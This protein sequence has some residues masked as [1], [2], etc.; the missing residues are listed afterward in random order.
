[1]I[2]LTVLAI[3]QLMTLLYD[4]S[5]MQLFAIASVLVS[6]AAIPIA[7]STSPMPDTP[8]A[9]S[10]DIPAVFSV[11]PIGALGC[12]ATGL[13]NGAF[14]A[15]APVFTWGI[16][17]ET[18]H[19]AWFMTAAV[20]GGAV[21]QWP[22]G[23]VSDRIGRRP[24]LIALPVTGAVFGIGLMLFSDTGS[25]QLI[26]LLGAAWGMFAFPLYAISVAYTNDYAGPHD[27]V[28]VSGSLLLLY[29]LGATI[30]PIAASAVLSVV[31]YRGLF[32][33]GAAIHM[34]LAAY[35][36]LRMTRVSL[37][38]PEEAVPFSDALTA[39][40]T[41][42]QVYEETIQEDIA[43]LSEQL[44]LDQPDAEQHGRK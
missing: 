34:L 22:L 43:G 23:T 42:S 1:M 30:G 33:F 2:T 29:G 37:T 41:A 32:A 24:L 44:C 4:P 21:A 18:S 31:G 40:Q 27:Y 19:A 25:F 8:H 13:T 36:I 7:L 16:S 28:T 10:I 39:S 12:L 3:G 14:W 6:I 26:C 38:V 15:L 35:A 5:G 9:V 20:V 11:A 17:Q